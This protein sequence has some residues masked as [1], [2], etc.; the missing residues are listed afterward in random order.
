[1]ERLI[2]WCF[3]IISK[4]PTIPH[5]WDIHFLYN[6]NGDDNGGDDDEMYKPPEGRGRWY[7]WYF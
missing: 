3:F 2:K 6:D 1:M 7:E 4:L 5:I